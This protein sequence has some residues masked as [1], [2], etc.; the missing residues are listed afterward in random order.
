MTFLNNLRSIRDWKDSSI[1]SEGKSRDSFCLEA[2]LSS[3]GKDRKHI[4]YKQSVIRMQENITLSFTLC[5]RVYS[6]A[7]GP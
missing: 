7:G 6:Q 2:D 5:D 4:R 1:Y 3:A